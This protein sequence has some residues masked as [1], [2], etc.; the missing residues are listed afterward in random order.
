M[1]DQIARSVGVAARKEPIAV[2]HPSGSGHEAKTPSPALQEVKRRSFPEIVMAV[3]GV[4][5]VDSLHVSWKKAGSRAA[6][7]VCTS[8]R[9]AFGLNVRACEGMGGMRFANEVALTRRRVEG[10][11]ETRQI[12]VDRRVPVSGRIDEANRQRPR[13]STTRLVVSELGGREPAVVPVHTDEDLCADPPPRARDAPVDI[14]TPGATRP[15]TFVNTPVELTTTPGGTSRRPPLLGEHTER[16]LAELET[17]RGMR[18]LPHASTGRGMPR[19]AADDLAHVAGPW[20]DASSSLQIN[21]V[22]AS[23][24]PAKNAMGR[25][26][27][28]RA[29]TST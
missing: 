25:C 6:E 2:G 23:G 13:R 16:E 12:H 19:Q 21:G 22:L 7:P 29:G 9:F 8:S 17:R 26:R 20:V 24:D 28:P 3:W 14:E 5:N 1:P 15:T 11:L 18:A 27:D 4:G 10:E